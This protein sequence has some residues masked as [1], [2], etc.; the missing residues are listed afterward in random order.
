MSDT[1]AEAAEYSARGGFTLFLG[2]FSST[3]VLAVA[4]ILV[5]RLLGS[6]NYGLYSLSLVAP[7]LLASLIGLGLDSAA[8]MFTS[9]YSAEEK[10]G[11]VASFLKTS[12]VFR[13]A[14]GLTASL[15]CFAASDFL[16]TILL[17]RPGLSF[18][19]RVFS[20]LILFQTFFTLAYSLFVGLGS[21]RWASMVK[22]L[23]AVFKAFFSP[24][25]LLLGLGVFGALL[26]H[27]LG[28]VFSA[29]AGLTVLFSRYYRRL[30]NSPADNDEEEGNP[31]S[32]GLLRLM[33]SYG[34]PLYLSSLLAILL[35]NYQTVLLAYY[36]SN[37]EI[38]GFQAAVNLSTMFTVLIT[39]VTTMLFPVFTRLYSTGARGELETFLNL[40][41]KYS[42]LILLPV[43]VLAVC[44]SGQLVTVVYG[45]GYSLASGYL[46]AYSL[47]FLLVGLGYGILGSFFNGV[48]ETW[49]TF[50][51]D[52]LSL[53]V[54]MPLSLLLTSLQGVMGLIAALIASR[55]SSTVYGL[56]L[57]RR[58]LSVKLNPP[59]IARIY[60]S[61]LLSAVPTV[62]IARFTGLPTLPSL[63]LSSS[64]YV[65]SYM[66]LTPLLRAVDE[67]DLR[68]LERMFGSIG[69][70]KPFVRLASGYV[71]MVLQASSSLKIA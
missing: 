10:H 55:V 49:L 14:T 60:V 43:S 18:Y 11:H 22:L 17:N 45:A 28:Y 26:A 29:L 32:T 71:R 64:V 40:S 1:L 56:V 13:L 59:R 35:G 57:A 67:D 15:T 66:S 2:E 48:G 19:V 65:F 46:A 63:L 41:V 16:A 30:K 21:P 38:G 61:T 70:L 50:R 52:L 12:I 53:V 68:S 5:A 27:T 42:S 25:L 34:F 24:V 37:A 51:T 44:V 54:F 58:R 36:A 4:S 9:K 39:P 33:L 7:S 23:M 6:E 31:G 8:V 69:V 47:M 62:L 3:T 20:I